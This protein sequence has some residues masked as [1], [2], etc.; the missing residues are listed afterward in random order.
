M[1][2]SMP[3]DCQL[4]EKNKITPRH[5]VV[6]MMITIDRDRI[7]KVA[8]STMEIKYKEANERC[9]AYLLQATH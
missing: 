7:L 9:T 8:R 4:K 1:T 6:T 2:F 3:K 5:M